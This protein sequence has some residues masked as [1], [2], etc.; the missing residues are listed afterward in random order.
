MVARG[1]M[2]LFTGWSRGLRDLAKIALESPG[3]LDGSSVA[4]RIVGKAA[5]VI[6]AVNGVET[7]YTL[8]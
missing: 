8:T 6:S 3:I 1:S 7:A 5:A 4:D 2:I